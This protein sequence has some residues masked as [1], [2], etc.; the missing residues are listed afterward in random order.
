MRNF[1]FLTSL[2]TASLVLAACSESQQQQSEQALAE[3]GEVV[4]QASQAATEVA[5]DVTDYAEQAMATDSAAGEAATAI[6]EPVAGSNASGKLVFTDLGDYLQVY[7]EASGLEP[8]AHAFHVHV[9]GDCSNNAQ[10][11]GGHLQFSTDTE[12]DIH[13]NLGEF[14]AAAGGSDKEL[15]VISVPL[16]EIV[17]RAVVFHAKGN[18]PSQPPGGGAG[19]RIACGV[20]Q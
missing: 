18:D 17:G 6:V 4:E 7:A 15:A 3:A 2:C 16:E 1:L 20:I 10:A 13:G 5:D 8:G 14:H 19:A 12:G 11:A 9:N